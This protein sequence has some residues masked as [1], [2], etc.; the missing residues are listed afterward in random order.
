MEDLRV[1]NIPQDRSQWTFYRYSLHSSSTKI[2]NVRPVLFVVVLTESQI[3]TFHVCFRYFS[4][5]NETKNFK[6]VEKRSARIDLLDDEKIRP[7][8]V[9]L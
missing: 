3:E 6:N 7:T 9:K 4:M 1:C 8:C 5:E 2:T